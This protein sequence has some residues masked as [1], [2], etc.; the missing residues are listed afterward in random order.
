MTPAHLAP[1]TMVAVL[2]AIT[3]LLTAAV[4]VPSTV[5]AAATAAPRGAAPG[6]ASPQVLPAQPPVP[7]SGHVAPLWRLDRAIRPVDYPGPYAAPDGI[8]EPGGYDPFELRA[9]LG[10]HGTGAGQTVAV[11]EAYDVQ[12][13]LPATYGVQH[14]V[15]NSLAGYDSWYGLPPA[16]SAAI[17]TSCFHLSFAAPQGTSGSLRYAFG[18]M[19]EAVLDVEMIHALAPAASITIVEGHDESDKSMMAAVQYAENLHPAA[20]SNSWGGDEFSGEHALDRSCPA[21]G[22]P[23]VFSSGDNGNYGT[24]LAENG[25]GAPCGGYPAAN[26]DVLAVGGTTLDLAATGEVISEAAWS[27]SGGGISAYEPL[28]AYQRQADPYTSGRGI[29]DVSFDA[30]PNSGVALYYDITISGTQHQS[31]QEVGGTSAGAPAWAAILASTAQLRSASGQAPLN[32][33]EVHAAVYA[34]TGKKPVADITTGAN[35]ICGRLCSAARGYDLVTGEGSPRRGVDT[36]L[37]R[38]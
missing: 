26:P 37:A 12:N 7:R 1:R 33:A 23:C 14:D 38:A 30:D 21:A 35:G 15:T 32:M 27:G 18:W 2:A 17:T 22:S 4:T 11:T 5:A 19:V 24:C 34:N 8:G 16:C 25:A 20:V 36:Y 10:L 28:P 31:W 29:P 13:P 3:A 6:H 9:Y